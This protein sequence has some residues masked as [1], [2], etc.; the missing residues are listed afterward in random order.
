MHTLFQTFLFP[1]FKFIWNSRLDAPIKRY[2][3]TKYG[4][5]LAG[6]VGEMIEGKGRIV[7]SREIYS[8]NILSVLFARQLKSS[9][10][11]DGDSLK[12]DTIIFFYRLSVFTFFLFFFLFFS[13]DLKIER[14]KRVSIW[15]NS[16]F[17]LV[18]RIHRHPEIVFSFDR[19]MKSK[20]TRAV[21]T[22][23][24]CFF[25]ILFL[26]SEKEISKTMEDSR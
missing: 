21:T 16:C 7:P 8:R 3:G 5:K 23:S 26:S 17:S 25:S 6:K 13:R 18:E 19:K 11:Y 24:A 14:E 20:H 12:L 2:H 9:H 1:S 22:A 15:I 4:L 10:F